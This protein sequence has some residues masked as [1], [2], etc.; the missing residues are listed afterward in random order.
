LLAWQIGWRAPGAS[1][2]CRRVVERV[3]VVGP[4]EVQGKDGNNYDQHYDGHKDNQDRSDHL[5]IPLT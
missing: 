5:T 2:V 3:G 4:Q 1:R